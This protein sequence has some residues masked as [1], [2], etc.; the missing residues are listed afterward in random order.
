MTIHQTTIRPAITPAEQQAELDRE[1]KLQWRAPGLT[2]VLPPVTSHAI[3]PAKKKRAPDSAAN[4]K[5]EPPP[6][7]EYPRGPRST[8]ASHIQL[9]RTR[10]SRL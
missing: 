6:A 9:M 10:S 8:P 7:P 3:P 1:M 2:A 5:S 4:A